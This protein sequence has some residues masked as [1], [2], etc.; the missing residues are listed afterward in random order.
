MHLLSWHGAEY[1]QF[2]QERIRESYRAIFKYLKDLFEKDKGQLRDEETQRG[3]Q[4]MMLLAAEAAHKIDN[5]TDIFKKEG[6]SVTE[7]KEYKE[8]QQYYLTKIVQRHQKTMESEEKWQKEWGAGVGEDALGVQK[9]GLKNLE[10]VRR[11]KDYELFL[12]RNEEGH[13]FFNRSLMHHLQLIGQFDFMLRD[14]TRENPFLRIPMI[15]DRDAQAAAK[16]VLHLLLCLRRGILTR[17][18]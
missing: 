13:P 1:H 17:K 3:V 18:H 2:N 9:G 11:D 16:E 15:L 6:E 8:L 12:I 5:Y 4:A 14:V 7:L 10:S